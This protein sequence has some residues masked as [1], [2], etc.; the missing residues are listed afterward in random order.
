[1][2]KAGDR[3]MVVT[4]GGVVI[5]GTVIAVDDR[6]LTVRIRKHL[7]ITVDIDSIKEF[8]VSK[9]SR[10]VKSDASCQGDSR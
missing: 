8:E 9:E 2:V 7:I 3:V 1:M 10:R 6:K 4:R 5:Y